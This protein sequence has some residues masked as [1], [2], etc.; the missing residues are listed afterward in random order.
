MPDSGS[1]QNSGFG[2][3]RLRGLK[4]ILH[5]HHGACSRLASQSQAFDAPTPRQNRLFAAALLESWAFHAL[6]NPDA[7][8]LGIGVPE[9]PLPD[10][11]LAKLTAQLDVWRNTELSSLS[12]PAEK[13]VLPISENAQGR[14]PADGRSLR[15]AKAMLLSEGTS[16]G[17]RSREKI[18]YLFLFDPA[19]QDEKQ[20]LW[21]KQ[22]VEHISLLSKTNRRCYA[23]TASDAG[24]SKAVECMRDFISEGSTIRAAGSPEALLSLANELADRKAGSW[25]ARSLFFPWLQNRTALRKYISSGMQNNLKRLFAAAA[26]E[27]RIYPVWTEAELGLALIGCSCG[28]FHQPIYWRLTE[29]GFC[30]PCVLSYPVMAADFPGSVLTG[31]GNCKCGLAAP[32]IDFSFN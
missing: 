9:L 12:I 26:G 28:N 22:L 10:T 23:D 5:K 15:C 25:P 8:R 16:L 18:N 20:S 21:A 7:G 6:H 27:S 14:V 24:L 30:S 31:R 11:Q 19:C 2:G 17:L 4:R 1:F 3:S 32:V 13:A 29:R